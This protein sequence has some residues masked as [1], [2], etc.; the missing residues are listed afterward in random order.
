MMTKLTINEAKKVRKNKLY[1]GSKKK[2]K[3]LGSY[4]KAQN[5]ENMKKYKN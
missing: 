1:K 4:I 5:K 3:Y 2:A